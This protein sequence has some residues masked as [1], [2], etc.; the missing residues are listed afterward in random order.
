[1]I[2]QAPV[3]RQEGLADDAGVLLNDRLGR[4]AGEDKEVQDAAN[5]PEGDGR[6]WL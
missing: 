1:M 5:C 6:C 4:R 2:A 3:G